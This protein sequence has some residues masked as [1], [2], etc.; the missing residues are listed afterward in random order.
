MKLKGLCLLLLAALLSQSASADED[1][2]YES[3]GQI[4]IGRVFL[5]PGERERLD[6]I[7]GK[8]PVRT[9]PAPPARPPAA[10]APQTKAAGFIISDSG[11]TRVWKDGNFVTADSADDV[12]FPRRIKVR[13]QRTA[14]RAEQSIDD[15]ESGTVPAGSGDDED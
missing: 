7:R 11:R 10:R 13:S 4:T 6:R 12:R 9:V 3:L 8:G 1:G 14:M 2:I 15:S 5:T